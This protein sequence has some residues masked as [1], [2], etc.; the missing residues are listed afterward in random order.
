LDMVFC[1]QKG[2]HCKTRTRMFM[3]ERKVLIKTF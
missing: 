3:P 2:L 1:L